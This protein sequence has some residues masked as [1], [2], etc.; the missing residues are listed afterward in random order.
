MN[1]EARAVVIAPMGATGPLRVLL[2]RLAGMGIECE[3][4]R[5]ED[6][7]SEVVAR[8]PSS[9]PCVVLDLRDA[10][11]DHDVEDVKR[12][13]EAVRSVMN[14]IPGC[15]PV[16]ITNDAD[17]ALI[18]ACVRAGAGDVIDIQLEGTQAARQVVQRIYQRQRDKANQDAQLAT[19]HEMI[20]DLL[21][22]L[23]RTERRSIDLE[24]KLNNTDT[25]PPAILL[26]EPDRALADRLVDKLEDLGVSTFAYVT[27]EE[28]TRAAQSPGQGPG[29]LYDLALVAAQLSDLDGLQTIQR[30][31]ESDPGLPAFL[32]TSVHDAQLAEQAA[33]LGV[34]G[35][36][37]KP[38]PD[39]D[40]VVERLSQLARESLMR[41]R[42][43]AYLER[44]KTRHD[45]V[46]ARYRALPRDGSA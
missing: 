35:F 22:D 8:S 23:I 13:A 16:V 10:T 4:V 30:L 38:I 41:T 18:V 29:V 27:G 24:D 31:R 2:E 39:L 1:A 37:H 43:H 15:V 5:D 21:K 14:A 26:V 19:L 44:I 6:A 9:P 3:V 40:D 20:E 7:A 12:A 32:M 11:S 42:E 28:A 46:L 36:V 25:R 45:R 17:A 34:V 33:D